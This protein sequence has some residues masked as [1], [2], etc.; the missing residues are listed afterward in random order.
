MVG[1]EKTC[2]ISNL[3]N[4]KNKRDL[5]VVLKGGAT[6]EGYKTFQPH[7]SGRAVTK[8]MHILAK[9]SF[10]INPNPEHLYS[11]DHV[12]NNVINN[13]AR[14]LLFA[15]Y[16][17]QNQKENKGPDQHHQK[18]KQERAVEMYDLD[19]NFIMEHASAGKAMDWLNSN[20]IA[21]GATTSIASCA[22]GKAGFL[23]AYGH[24][25]KF[26][27]VEDMPG[28][29]WKVVP[30]NILKSERD[31]PYL[32]SNMGRIK[33]KHGQLIQGRIHGRKRLLIRNAGKEKV[34]ANVI[35]DTF[36][37]PNPDNKEYVLFK[38]NNS[39]DNALLNLERAT[40]SELRRH[41]RSAKEQKT[42]AKKL[43]VTE[44]LDNGTKIDT[45]YNRQKDAAEHIDTYPSVMTRHVKG[46]KV[47][48]HPRNGRKYKFTYDI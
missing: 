14:N 42:T 8:A 19:D 46:N 38:N 44:I 4:V 37:V 18:D 13:D 33:N 34:W 48:T 9:N 6:V 10:Y 3:G 26:K 32:A 36:K 1:F 16:L 43:Q 28:E 25:W 22:K 47:F 45:V 11:I 5:S 27:E 20:G 7:V 40:L 30:S 31:G 39:Q 24:K 35:V 21:A 15:S 41:E 23:S 29:I 2:V 17:Y 12:D